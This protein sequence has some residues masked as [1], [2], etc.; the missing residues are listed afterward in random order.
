MSLSVLLGLTLLTCFL[1]GSQGWPTYSTYVKEIDNARKVEETTFLWNDLPTGNHK[2]ALPNVQLLEQT[3]RYEIEKKQVPDDPP[4]CLGCVSGVYMVQYYIKKNKTTTE[5]TEILQRLCVALNYGAPDFCRDLAHQMG[6]VVVTIL[7]NTSNTPHEVCSFVHN[8]DCGNG[9]VN[10]H[11]WKLKIPGGKPPVVPR[12]PPKSDT[13]KLRVL[14]ITDTH[15]DP[16]YKEGTKAVCDRWLC[17]R[18]ECGMALKNESAAGKWG[19]WKCDIPERTLDSFLQHANSTHGRFDYILWTGDIPSHA[20]WT[21][22]KE[23]SLYMLRSTVGKILKYF[24][25]TPIFPALGNH[26]GSPPNLYPSPKIGQSQRTSWLYRELA[27]QWSLMVP[28]NTLKTIEFGAFYVA[29]VRPRLKVIS[30]NTN[31]CYSSNWW[32]ILNSTDPADMLKWFITELD[33]AERENVKVH[34]IG[35]IPP[36][37]VDCLKIWG[38]N[39]Y[40]II[41]RYE[42]TVTAQFY[43]HTH[44]DEIDIYYDSETKQRP[45][46]VGYIGPSVTTFVDGNPAYRIYTIDGDH[47]DS[48]YD[49]VDFEGWIMDLEK[50][51]R[52]EVAHWKKLY[53]AKESYGLSSLLPND[54]NAFYERL[55]TDDTLM[56]TYDRHYW[57]DSPRRPK[58]GDECRR[59]HL[60]DIRSGVHYGPPQY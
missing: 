9:D 34:V 10:G 30:L 18:T 6:E 47:K 15:Y 54:W 56:D 44:T 29:P 13:P 53:S 45:V 52:D 22:T 55:K 58:C 40:D 32:L 36:G 7:T 38:N 20:S 42:N 49:V 24:P 2:S 46:S 21:Q 59:S 51:N 50:S 16:L 23:E 31:F 35:H 57:K 25:N 11:R 12:P 26:E 14:H 27:R 48:S 3:T 39:F 28:E 17:C 41:S 43:G 5:I 19:G 8:I 4:D 1:S 37:S 60:F 33:K